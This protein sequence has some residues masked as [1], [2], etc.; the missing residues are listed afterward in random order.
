MIAATVN[1]KAKIPAM[2]KTSSGKS[3]TEDPIDFTRPE[4]F[5]FIHAT[6]DGYIHQRDRSLTEENETERALCGQLM[7]ITT[8][9]LSANIVVLSNGDLLKL[10]SDAQRALMLAGV[11]LLIASIAAGIKYYFQ[12][13][14]FHF[15]WAKASNDVVNLHSEVDFKTFKEAGRKVDAIYKDVPTQTPKRWLHWQIKLLGV[16]SLSYL[17]LLIAILFDFSFITTPLLHCLR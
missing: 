12:L 16:G 7:L 17:L 15:D 13:M 6:R 14:H 1:R 5:G 8:V 9:L 4:V 10:M 11:I 2:L 3:P